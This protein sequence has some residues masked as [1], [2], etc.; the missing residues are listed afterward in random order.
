[1]WLMLTFDIKLCTNFINYVSCCHLG[2]SF[3]HSKQI[4]QHSTQLRAKV[5]QV[6]IKRYGVFMKRILL[7]GS[8]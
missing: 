7:S 5:R 2:N 6:E 3:H 8:M 4:D 1:M